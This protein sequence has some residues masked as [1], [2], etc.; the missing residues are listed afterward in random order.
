L[1]IN[2]NHPA[3]VDQ[4]HHQEMERKKVLV[5]RENLVLLKKKIRNQLVSQTIQNT[6][7]KKH[8]KVHQLVERKKA[9]VLMERKSLKAEVI[10]LKALPSKNT[11]KRELKPKIF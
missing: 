1:V 2:Q 3:T 8:L 4:V 11:V 5:I 7:E 6:S 9:L 10:D